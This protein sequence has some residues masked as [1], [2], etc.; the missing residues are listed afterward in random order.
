MIFLGLDIVDI[1]RFDN[2]F[3]YSDKYLLKIFSINEINY[4]KSNIEKSAERFALR[5]AFKESLYKALNQ[6]M[7]KKINFLQFSKL[8]SLNT[9]NANELPKILIKDELLN[10]LNIK[11]FK[12]SFSLSHSRLSAVAVVIVYI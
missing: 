7:L 2:W 3:L 4:C 9:L 1:Q 12:L 10:T 5:F 11:D 8:C 6:F